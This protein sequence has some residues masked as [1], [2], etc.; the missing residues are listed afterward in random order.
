[1]A[2]TFSDQQYDLC[3]PSGVEHHWWTT[4]RNELLTDIL[5]GESV[6]SSVLLEV[7][8]GRGVVVKSLRDC[9][10]NIHGVELAD[11]EPIDGAHPFVDSATDANEW[12]LERR[13][14]VT[15]L[16]LLDVIEHLPEP[17]TFLRKLESNFPKLSA[18]IVTVPARQELWS[19]YDVFY[20]HHR[21]YS[22]ASL[23][24][25]AK[26]LGWTTERAG[27]FFRMPYLPG[28]ILS[29]LGVDR[30][31]TIK[32]PSKAMR[33]VHGL[34]SAVCQLE[35]SVLPRGIPGTSAYAVYY[36][37]KAR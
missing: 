3:Y 33:P 13:S 37:H 8:C 28:R 20:G 10:F 25:L 16:L 31:T 26:D 22:I 24:K 1:M 23:E 5:K 2:T 15:G 32:A 4:A 17:E 34:V 7:G 36:P 19:N 21:R 12:A 18:V 11:V 9:G 27:Y 29:L 14:E 35:Q 6:D 30:G